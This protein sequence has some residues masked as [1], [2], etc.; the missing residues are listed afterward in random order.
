MRLLGPATALSALLIASALGAQH[1]TSSPA[2][3]ESAPTA[4]KPAARKHP[5]PPPTHNPQPELHPALALDTIQRGHA[6]WLAA[7]QQGLPAPELP[8]RPAG[9]GR[10]VVGVLACADCDVDLAERFGLRRADVLVLRAPGPFASAEDV[11]LLRRMVLQER[12]SL[13]VVLGHQRCEI[14]QP[15]R[16]VPANDLLAA[17]VAVVERLAQQQKKPLLATFLRWQRQALLAADD[18]LRSAADQDR[19]RVVAAE[20]DPASQAITWLLPPIEALPMPPVK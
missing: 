4:T 8:P 6:A 11:A 14:L 19:L 10:H 1:P 20:F 3:A 15:T 16:P 9:A 2:A 12:L 5:E 17:R 7:H 18:D 13:I